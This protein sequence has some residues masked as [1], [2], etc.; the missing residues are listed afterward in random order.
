MADV[1]LHNGDVLGLV[2]VEICQA[3][4]TCNNVAIARSLLSF[5]SRFLL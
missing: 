5:C 3:L 2:R 1:K 4:Q